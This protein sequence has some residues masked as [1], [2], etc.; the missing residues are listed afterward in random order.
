MNLASSYSADMKRTDLDKMLLQLQPGDCSGTNNAQLGEYDC[1][2]AS[3]AVD[4]YGGS[5]Y[6]TDVLLEASALSN[7]P[8][9]AV[10]DSRTG[11]RPNSRAFVSQASDRTGLSPVPPTGRSTAPPGSFCIHAESSASAPKRNPAR[12][13]S[14]TPQTTTPLPLLRHGTATATPPWL[15]PTSHFVLSQKGVVHRDESPGREQSVERE[16]P[17]RP[18]TAIGMGQEDARALAGQQAPGR[19]NRTHGKTGDRGIASQEPWSSTARK[20]RGTQS[21][22]GGRIIADHWKSSSLI[23]SGNFHPKAATIS[24]HA[25]ASQLKRMLQV[26]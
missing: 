7:E 3:T 6:E 25:Q 24:N 11:W 19:H 10:N 21:A 8:Q 17:Q 2:K 20:D 4:M 9:R 13:S 18:G 15:N 23:K 1:S 22:L 14:T 16:Q 12:S 26:F 5:S